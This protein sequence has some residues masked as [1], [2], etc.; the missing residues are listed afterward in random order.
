MSE[1]TSGLLR[2][3]MHLLRPFWLVATLATLAGT[4]SGLATASL[5]ATIN[6]SL[7]S[8]T[9]ITNQLILTFV[10]LFVVTLVGEIISDIGNTLVGQRIIASLRNDLSAKILR[11]PIVEIERYQPHRML[12]ALNQD[13][14]TISN[15]TFGFSGFAIAVAVTLGCFAY[16]CWLSPIMFLVTVIAV[17]LGSIATGWARSKGMRGFSITRDA[18]DQLQKHYRSI[19]E[20]AKELRMHRPRRIDMYTNKIQAATRRI[21]EAFM[22]GVVV[23]CAA[24]AFG[25]A[26]FFFVI[27]LLL[28]LHSDAASDQQATIGGF[29]L[30]L[31]YVKGPL[32]QI[33]GQFPMFARAQI[34]MK[35]LAEL[36]QRFNSPETGLTLDEQHAGDGEGEAIKTIELRA[37][38][39]AFPAPEGGNAF[40]LGPIDLC[41][42]AGEILFITGENGG[43]KTT[44]IKLLLGLYAPASGT[45]LV[46]GV[47]LS[48]DRLD[49]YRQSFATIFSDYFLFDEL[50]LPEGVLPDEAVKYLER[51]EIANKVTVKD[52]RFTTTDLSTGQ[53]KRL[54]LI[55]TWV[56]GRPLLVF[57][58]WAAD[59]DPEFRRVFYTEILPALKQQG[60]TV[61]AISHDDRY[62]HVADRRVTL[63]DGQMAENRDTATASAPQPV[64]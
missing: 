29:V 39:F 2:T 10:V 56:E 30:V 18:E 45:I 33:I 4:A 57:D 37:V 34:A 3:V 13:I 8:S 21:V 19:I 50:S 1:H 54:A 16:M 31:L 6:H 38:K 14:S 25:S 40:V 28:V 35:R 55:H 26:L 58:E 22:G 63:R 11:A 9:G 62:F 52:G 48:D 32:T 7:H 49:G 12:T 17:A 24:N 51:L 41:L 64:A 53:R 59:Q 20:G 60:R 27:G 23:F 61:I 15:F 47:P 42:Q 36:S 5:L 44:L 46:N 43:G